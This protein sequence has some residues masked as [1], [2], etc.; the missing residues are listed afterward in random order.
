MVLESCIEAGASQNTR[1]AVRTIESKG[2]VS[3]IY[4]L[5]G[6]IADLDCNH[7][8]SRNHVQRPTEDM[9]VEQGQVILPYGSGVLNC[10]NFGDTTH[11]SHIGNVY[12][13]SKTAKRSK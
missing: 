13:V 12:N 8:N 6:N 4:V 11:N 7:A 3:K 5:D 1:S 9:I 2:N 10:G